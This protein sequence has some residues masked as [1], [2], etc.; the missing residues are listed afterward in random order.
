PDGSMLI[1]EKSGEL[2][3]FSNGQK[4]QVQG[5]PEIE[6]LGQG[7]LLDVAVHPDFDSNGWIYLTYA[8][9]EGEGNGGHTALTRAKLGN[10]Q[11]VEKQL[12]YKGSPNSTAGQHFGSRIVFDNNGDL[13]FTIGDRGDEHTNP[14][15]ITRDGGK[16]YRLHEDG[17][18][19]EDNPF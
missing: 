15:D 17:S 7:G 16:V 14:Q 9:S 11:L 18:I 3:H 5:V 12:L 10:G 4:Q 8:S 2:F 6:Q 19:P 1:T 13:F